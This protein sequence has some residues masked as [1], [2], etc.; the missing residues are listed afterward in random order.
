MRKFHLLL[1]NIN[2]MILIFIVCVFIAFFSIAPIFNLVEQNSMYQAQYDNLKNQIELINQQYETLS[3]EPYREQQLRGAYHYSLPDD[4]IF[5][6]P[7]TESEE[8]NNEG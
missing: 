7:H 4:I 5:E 1:V 6:F 2:M 8:S 3:Q